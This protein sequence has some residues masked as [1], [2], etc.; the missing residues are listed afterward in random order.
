MMFRRYVAP[1][2]LLL[3]PGLSA[4]EPGINP[5]AIESRSAAILQGIQT[6]ARPEV[7]LLILP[8]GGGCTATLLTDRHFLTAAHCINYQP[9]MAGGTFFVD[10]VDGFRHDFPVDRI[11]S[12]HNKAPSATDSESAK[13]DLAVGR[14]VNPV[15]AH[16][17]TPASLQLDRPG[18]RWP[19]TAMGYGREENNQGAGIKR[20]VHFTFTGDN[21]VINDGDS[22]G[23]VFFGDLNDRGRLLLVH[24]HVKSH[25]FGGAHDLFGD[26]LLRFWEIIDLMN[27]FETDGICYRVFS[28]RNGYGPARCNGWEAGSDEGFVGVEMWSR[29]GSFCYVGHPLSLH[30]RTERCGGDLLGLR[31]FDHRAPVFTDLK[32]RV[33]SPGAF[34][35]VFYQALVET[36]GWTPVAR[37][38]QS[39]VTRQL[40]WPLQRIRIWNDF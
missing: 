32:V 21:R 18:S 2:A 24:S 11:M 19:A 38:G 12:V 7:G 37:D 29:D 14:L 23:P 13:Y 17:A 34:P 26:P 27:A 1:V 3:A 33:Q 40:G 31:T 10:T 9:F 15:P 22:G 16:M 36:Q 28:K 6:T 30:A 8:N 25:I 39:V 35:S 5:E 4:C 20:Y